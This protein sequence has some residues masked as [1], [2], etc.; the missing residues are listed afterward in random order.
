MKKLSHEPRGSVP[1]TPN[2][3]AK[4]SFKPTLFPKAKSEVEK[5][6]IGE[7]KFNFE[8]YNKLSSRIGN[9]SLHQ[10]VRFANSDT[11]DNVEETEVSETPCQMAHSS[12]TLDSFSHNLIHKE[13]INKLEEKVEDALGHENYQSLLSYGIKKVIYFI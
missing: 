3:M 6:F 11:E 13:D 9:M 1:L 7:D 10:D 8:R 4:I 12:K 5:A 2:N